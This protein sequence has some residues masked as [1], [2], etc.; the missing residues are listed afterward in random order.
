MKFFS[1]FQIQKGFTL[2]EL[3]VVISII[4]VLAAIVLPNLLGIRERARDTT[5]KQNLVELRNA[6]R[7]YYNDYQE[8]PASSGAGAIV[9]CG[10]ADAP[11]G[12]AC[13]SGFETSGANGVMYMRQLPENFHYTQTDAGFDY[14]LYAVLENVSDADIAK[15]VERCGITEPVTGA[16]YMCE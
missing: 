12:G 11:D 13:T 7:L 5:V 15:S 6:L 3:L 8:Y 1:R 14:V 2:V 16:Y 10:S 4:G 9:G